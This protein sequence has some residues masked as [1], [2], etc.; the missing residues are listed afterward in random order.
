MKNPAHE[1]QKKLINLM[2]R[3]SEV[4]LELVEHNINPDYFDECFQP[5]VQA[6]YYVHGL[7]DGTRLLT[8]DHYRKLLI[9]Q[10]GKG[11]ITI[12]MQVQYECLYGVHHSNSRND[13]D[14]LVQQVT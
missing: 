3:H 8:E 5:L 14:M 6:I 4:V 12:A 1:L 10:G 2:L 9:E 11:D 7:S 13:L